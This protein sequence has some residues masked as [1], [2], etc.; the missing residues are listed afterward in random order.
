MKKAGLS[1]RLEF[2]LWCVVSA[3]LIA[4]AMS[5]I[6]NERTKLLANTI[7]AAG[8]TI[9]GGGFVAPLIAW[10]FGVPGTPQ[11]EFWAVVSISL[12]WLGGGLVLH[13][14]ARAVLG[15]LRE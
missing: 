6:H 13:F 14:I 8:T 2:R 10:S 7:S 9:I 1:R 5:L 4:H 15:R 3:S 11:M 12:N